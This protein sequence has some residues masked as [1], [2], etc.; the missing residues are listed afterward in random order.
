MSLSPY[1][2]EREARVARNKDVLR[3]LGVKHAAALLAP[4]IAAWRRSKPAAGAR[5]RVAVAEV[6]AA[7]G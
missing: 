6:A 3:E 4:P 1:E 2:K 7:A 5:K